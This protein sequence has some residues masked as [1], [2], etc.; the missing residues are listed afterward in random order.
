MD[1]FHRE[2]QAFMDQIHK[3]LKG[4]GLAKPGVDQVTSFW[5]WI[6][7][8]SNDPREQVRILLSGYVRYETRTVEAIR[9]LEWC[10]DFESSHLLHDVL[11][12]IE[13]CLCFLEMYL[14][15][16]ALSV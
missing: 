9:N 1:G 13:R 8:E 11:E 14:E 2:L 3:R 7:T 12:Y 15:E 6:D 4:C 10:G 5:N 16:L